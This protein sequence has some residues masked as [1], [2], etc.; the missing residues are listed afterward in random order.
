MEY[1][2]DIKKN[3]VLP[4]NETWMDLEIVIMTAVRKTNTVYHLY[5]ESKN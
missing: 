1:Y 4:F 3:E 5:V 2:L